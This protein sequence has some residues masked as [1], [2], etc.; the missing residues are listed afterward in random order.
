LRGRGTRDGSQCLAGRVGHEVKVEIAAGTLRHDDNGTNCELMG[1]R[2]RAQGKR[3]PTIDRVT[4]TFHIVALGTAFRGT[5][6][7]DRLNVN[8]HWISPLWIIRK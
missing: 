1:R 5:R 7:T 2:P 4:Q 6:L 3:K 8:G